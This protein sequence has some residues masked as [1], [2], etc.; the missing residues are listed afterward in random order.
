MKNRLFAS[1]GRM[2]H[3]SVLSGTVLHG[4]LVV[5]FLAHA[6]GLRRLLG[7]HLLFCLLM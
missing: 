3:V 2:L 6:A 7:V 5:V 4:V 1:E